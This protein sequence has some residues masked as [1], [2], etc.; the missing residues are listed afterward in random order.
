VQTHLDDGVVNRQV[1][2]KE[3]PCRKAGGLKLKIKN[4]TPRKELNLKENF[5]VW[6]KT[7]HSR[8]REKKRKNKNRERVIKPP[9]GP[10]RLQGEEAKRAN[11]N[12]GQI[13]SGKEQNI[14]WG[15]N[16]KNG[17]VK[18]GASPRTK[19]GIFL[20]MRKEDFC[21]GTVKADQQ[22]ENMRRN[23]EKD[24]VKV[25]QGKKGRTKQRERKQRTNHE[26][27]GVRENRHETHEFQ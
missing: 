10:G 12:S 4:K 2:M 3:V 24:R 17:G 6:T 5:R 14:P 9:W 8:E 13:L 26:W 7:R 27:G 22:L 21:G 23:G 25:V 19:T 18:E 16:F 1:N 11:Y 20:G 15:K